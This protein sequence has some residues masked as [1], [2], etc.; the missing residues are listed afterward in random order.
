MN[1]SDSLSDVGHVVPPT[2]W[3]RFYSSVKPTSS[4]G[5]T[6]LFAFC[7][8]VEIG[9]TTYAAVE[10]NLSCVGGA[11]STFSSVHAFTASTTCLGPTCL[12]MLVVVSL[13]PLTLVLFDSPSWTL[14]LS[15]SVATKLRRTVR[16][17]R[18]MGVTTY[19]GAVRLLLSKAETTIWA[20]V[21]ILHIR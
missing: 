14:L 5:H 7:V 8:E 13:H 9:A 15:G 4:W 6:L 1:S 2:R 12:D 18:K 21:C 17:S 11:V 16:R 10:V 3:S 19:R 20:A